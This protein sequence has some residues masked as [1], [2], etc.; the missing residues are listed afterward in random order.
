[1]FKAK[2]LLCSLLLLAA[3]I[4]QVQAQVTDR[5]VRITGVAERQ[6]D[7]VTAS[8]PVTVSEVAPNDYRQQRYKSVEQ[9]RDELL[10]ELVKMG[11]GS[12]NLIDDPIVELSSSSQNKRSKKYNISLPKGFAVGRLA[13]IYLEGVS[14]RNPVYQFDDPVPTLEDD[15]AKEAI[16]N[17]RQRAETMAGEF[18]KCLGTVLN[19]EDKSS[20]CCRKINNNNLPSVKLY[21]RVTM[22]FELLE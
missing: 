4:C 13:D 1:M 6:F 19:L 22:T 15:M 11:L 9:V 5:F 3:G 8:V 12:E 14:M 16:V 21:Y 20:G 2:H 7:A 17:A 10:A 18:G